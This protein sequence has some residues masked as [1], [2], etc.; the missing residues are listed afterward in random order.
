MTASQ[1]AT[2][3]TMAEAD[4]GMFKSFVSANLALQVFTSALA[5]IRLPR[6]SAVK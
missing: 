6:N 1:S 2:A 4:P 5:I 3:A